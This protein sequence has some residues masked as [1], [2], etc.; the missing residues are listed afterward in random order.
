MLTRT[1][2]V[3]VRHAMRRYFS[4]VFAYRVVIVCLRSGSMYGF[5]RVD[6]SFVEISA[7][8]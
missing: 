3:I 2:V 1:K 7:I 6:G 4:D 8:D 5:G